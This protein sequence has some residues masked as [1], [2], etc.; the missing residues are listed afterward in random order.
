LKG[1]YLIDNSWMATKCLE[2]DTIVW[3]YDDWAFMGEDRF[4]LRL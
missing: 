4:E 1:V 3:Q 2:Q